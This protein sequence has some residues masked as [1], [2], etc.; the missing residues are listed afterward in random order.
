MDSIRRSHAEKRKTACFPAKQAENGQ[1]LRKTPDRP[2]HPPARERAFNIGYAKSY[3]PR[4]APKPFVIAA[5][6][7]IGM[8][9]PTLSPS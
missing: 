1:F 4:S 5:E 9:M 7:P 2:E 8:A 6:I 3:S